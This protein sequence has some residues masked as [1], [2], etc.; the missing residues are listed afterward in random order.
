MHISRPWR[1]HVQSLKKIGIKMYEEL[2]SQVTH[3]LYTFI[4]YEV[5]KWQSEKSEKSNKN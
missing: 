5:R 1:K 3:S 4:E 2:R